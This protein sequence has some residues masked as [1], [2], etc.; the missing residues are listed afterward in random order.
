MSGE[1]GTCS[2]KILLRFESD[3]IC[4]SFGFL[5]ICSVVPL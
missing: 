5:I 2:K 3:K 4:S 1:E